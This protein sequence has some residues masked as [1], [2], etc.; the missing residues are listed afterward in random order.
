VLL[1]DLLPSG[2]GLRGEVFGGVVY[3]ADPRV[4]GV[5]CLRASRK[6]ERLESR[7]F[8]ELSSKSGWLILL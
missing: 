1:V 8:F 3:L 4:G 5:T 2:A 7:L 6:S